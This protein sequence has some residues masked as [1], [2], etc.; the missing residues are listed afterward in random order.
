MKKKSNMQQHLDIHLKKN[1]K[2]S[3]CNKSYTQRAYMKKHETSCNKKSSPTTT[4]TTT[5]TTTTT[6]ERMELD[7]I[8]FSDEFN[9]DS[10]K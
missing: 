7:D 4:I 3:K 1:Y 8:N 10:S 9:I 6:D 2:C 5:A